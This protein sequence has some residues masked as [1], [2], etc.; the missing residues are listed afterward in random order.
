MIDFISTHP[1]AHPQ[2]IACAQLLAAVI[3]Q[4]IDDASNKH[5]AAGDQ[6]AA[7]NWLFNESSNFKHYAMLIGADA[8]AIR[9]ALLAPHSST[10]SDPIKNKYPATKRRY[11]QVNYRQWLD[12]Q[13]LEKKILQEMGQA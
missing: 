11:L 3:A 4:A 12:R 8:Q 5:C 7:I 9:E 1:D 13:N 6:A 10:A 2:T